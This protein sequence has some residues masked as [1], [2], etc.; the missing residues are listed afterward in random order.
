M[1]GRGKANINCNSYLALYFLCK[2]IGILPNYAIERVIGVLVLAS[3]Q[4]CLQSAFIST[5]GEV[6]AFQYIWSCS[7][8]AYRIAFS[9]G[10]VSAGKRGHVHL[11]K[12]WH[13]IS[14]ICHV[15][16]NNQN[17]NVEEGKHNP[18]NIIVNVKIRPEGDKASNQ[19]NE[20]NLNGETKS[21]SLCSF[22]PLI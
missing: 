6:S 22:L 11:M 2:R 3:I 18:S 14:V 4:S 1:E 10:D 15:C 20:M 5:S 19:N 13:F 8:L 17:L 12:C 16:W 21:V 7:L 9:L